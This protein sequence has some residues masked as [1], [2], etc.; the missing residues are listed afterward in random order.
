M[1]TL[2][3]ERLILRPFTLDDLDALVVVL[4]DKMSNPLAPYDSPFPTS[5][6]EVAGVLNYF[7][8]SDGWYAVERAADGE[9]IGF[10]TAGMEQGDEVCELGYDIR[11]DCWRQ[12]YGYEA[13]RAVCDAM[14]AAGARRFTAGTAVCNLGSVRLLEKL[15]FVK[16]SE[17]EA[18]FIKDADGRAIVFTAGEFVLDV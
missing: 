1:E 16:A 4:R 12:G 5:P 11:S 14:I 2:T 6:E 7:S 17:S 13:C 9:L 3:T 10:I 8:H 18:S 15:G